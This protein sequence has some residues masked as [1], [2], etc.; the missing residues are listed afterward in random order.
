LN[1][2]EHEVQEALEEK[3]VTANPE[4]LSAFVDN[5]SPT[6]AARTISRLSEED[7]TQLLTK[8]SPESAADLIDELPDVQAAGIIEHLRPADAAA[9]VAELPSDEQADLVHD[10]SPPQAEAILSALPAEEASQVRQL[11]KYED[12]VAGGLMVTEF[13]AYPAQATVAD[14]VNDL[15]RNVDKYG[16][17]EVQYAYVVDNED[18]L[19]GV[20][21]LRDLLLAPAERPIQQLMIARPMNVGDQSTLDQLREFFDSH[22]YFAV[23][24][25]DRQQRLVGVVRRSDVEEALGEKSESDFRRAA[26]IVH[27]EIRTMPLLT[28]ARRRLAW[29]SVNI[30]LNVIA[31]SVIAVYQDTL[32][33]VIAL[34]VF[35]PI[36]SDMS[37]C[38]GNQAVAVSM[39]EL[40]LG[41]LDASEVTRVW[42]KELA[43]GILNGLALGSL[44]AAV[45]FLWKGNLYLGLVVGAAMMLNTL[46]AVTLGGTLPLA[47]KR[48]NVDPALASGP[49]LTT[50]TDMCGFF[51]ILSLATIMLP[52]LVG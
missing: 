20:L 29:L 13:L 47:L 2:H 30:M 22:P 34:A 33:Q 6:D 11:S 50:V 42:L 5:L 19:R 3:L 48:L 27:E 38:S 37:G 21:R 15:R 23:P 1:T 24:A 45:A 44:I 32:A 14:V 39:R 51:L 9:I 49:I 10:L 26:G 18:R 28:R 43:V 31:A 41:V 52:R 12:D 8:L 40:S 36:I 4:Q 46:L 25:T 35:I 7:Q 17:Y 16:E